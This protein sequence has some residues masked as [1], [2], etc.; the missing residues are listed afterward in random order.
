MEK[1]ISVAGN[2]E[3]VKLSPIRNKLF[4]IALTIITA[5]YV[6]EF[7]TS[8]LSPPLRGLTLREDWL[9]NPIPWTHWATPPY[10]VV[11]I[12]SYVALACVLYVINI[13]IMRQKRGVITGKPEA[14]SIEAPAGKEVEAGVEEMVESEAETVETGEEVSA[15]EEEKEL[16]AKLSLRITRRITLLYILLASEIL[17]FFAFTRATFWGPIALPFTILGISVL[18]STLLLKLFLICSAVIL[19]T[20]VVIYIS[21]VLVLKD[22]VLRLFGRTF[23]TYAEE[24]SEID[25]DGAVVVEQEKPVI[26]FDKFV[27]ETKYLQEPFV[28]RDI[29]RDSESGALKYVL[30]EPE[31]TEEEKEIYRRIV[32]ILLYE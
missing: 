17:L 29:I 20:I 5:I 11:F 25:V 7:A 24:E 13:L 14:M 12:G 16:E 3:G 28:Y 10:Y 22:P 2:E 18:S 4:Q 19:G 31:L 23:E 30:Y 8:A 21:I 6:L 27:I 15:A 26:E 32:D 1:G 9:T